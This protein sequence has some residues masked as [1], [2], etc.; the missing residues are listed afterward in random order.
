MSDDAAS[1]SQRDSSF[2]KGGREAK[3]N[4]GNSGRVVLEENGVC[5]GSRLLIGGDG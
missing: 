4:S 5:L 1:P 2:H 3:R